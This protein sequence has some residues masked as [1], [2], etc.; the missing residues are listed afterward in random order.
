MPDQNDKNSQPA[1]D[2]FAT[3]AAPWMGQGAIFAIDE[4]N[5]GAGAP[6]GPDLGRGARPG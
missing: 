1:I 6:T 3:L 2:R 4:L 5:R